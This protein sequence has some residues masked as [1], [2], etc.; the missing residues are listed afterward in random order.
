LIL[1]A[2]DNAEMASYLSELLRDI[3]DVRLAADGQVAIDLAKTLTPAL[4]LADV[5]MPRIDGVEVC[6]FLKSNPA[7]ARIPVILLTALTHREAM[8]KGWEAGADEYLFKPFHPAEVRTR[9]RTLLQGVAERNRAEAALHATHERAGVTLA[10]IGDGVITTDASGLIETLNPAA[11]ALTGWTERDARGLPL[12]QVFRIVDKATSQPVEDLVARGMAGRT[13]MGL[14]SGFR[15][16]RRDGMERTVADSAAPIRSRQGELLGMVLVFRDVGREQ[17][18]ANQLRQ[19]QKMEAIGHLTGGVAHDFN[20]L[21]GVILANAEL[22]RADLKEGT[23]KSPETLR[24]LIAAAKQG[25]ELV[26]QL[27]GFSRQELLDLRR[28]DPGR[29]VSD[30]FGTL[31]RLLPESI[32]IRTQIDPDVPLIRVDRGAMEQILLNLATNARDAMP[33]GGTLDV[34]VRVGESG[35]LDDRPGRSWQQAPRGPSVVIA[36]SDSGQGMDQGTLKRVFEPFFSTKGPALGTGL[37]MAMVYGLTKQQGGWVNLYSAP[38]EGTSVHLHFPIATPGAESRP[39]EPGAT[40][41]HPAG[42]EPTTILLAEDDEPLRRAST[43]V[44]KRLGYRVLSAID[45]Q[46]ALDLYRAQPDIDLV[47]TDVIMPR[48]GGWELLREIRR[49]NPDLPFL[50]VSGYAGGAN[51]GAQLADPRVT[52]LEKPWTMVE[53]AERVRRSLGEPAPATS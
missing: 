26:R 25:G 35:E 5:M 52:Y 39:P 3:A 41:A 28:L 31:R 10:S 1:V 36:V 46:E 4:V 29:L 34:S 14:G 9:V 43:T 6:R 2:E 15:L 24:D 37:G 13:V 8:L 22:I 12:N 11:E 45:G 49:S 44:L 23:G 7:T 16:I 53:L 30:F 32:E 51:A 19:A 21:L 27:L 48:L 47:V 40:I 38:G 42:A 20:N 18:V 50:V 33:G 17:Y